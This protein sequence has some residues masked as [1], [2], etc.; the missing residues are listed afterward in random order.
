MKKIRLEPAG[1][2]LEAYSVLKLEY[3][4]DSPGS[5]TSR[6]DSAG[7]DW[8]LKFCVPNKLADAVGIAD[9]GTPLTI[10]PRV[11]CLWVS[12]LYLQK[13]SGCG[14]QRP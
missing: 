4:Y 9:P 10:S 11:Y 13:V 6:S 8:G 1:G 3:A 2:N 7:Q 14:L 5:A 12:G